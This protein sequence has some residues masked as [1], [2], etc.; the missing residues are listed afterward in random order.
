MGQCTDITHRP[1]LIVVA[2][3]TLQHVAMDV[4]DHNVGV[5][6]TV[7]NVGYGQSGIY[8]ELGRE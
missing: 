2:F 1:K 6:N 7:V 4:G 3:L 5:Y 8:C